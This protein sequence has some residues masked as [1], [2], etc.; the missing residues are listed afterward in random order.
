MDKQACKTPPPWISFQEAYKVLLTNKE[1]KKI[2]LLFKPLAQTG[3]MSWASH[4]AN[5]CRLSPINE[6]LD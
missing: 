3:C 5:T 6:T 1:H 2:Q 4:L